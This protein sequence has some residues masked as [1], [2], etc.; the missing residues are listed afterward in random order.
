MVSSAE[1]TTPELF[2]GFKSVDNAVDISAGHQRGVDGPMKRNI[3]PVRYE[4]HSKTFEVSDV[5]GSGSGARRGLQ[6]GRT[7]SVS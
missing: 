5:D 2:D 3:D 7:W 1:L 4:D 6:E